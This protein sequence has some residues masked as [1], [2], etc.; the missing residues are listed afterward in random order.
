MIAYKLVHLYKDGSIGPLFI[1]R[2]QRFIIDKQYIAKCIPTKGFK[3]RPGFHCCYSMNA[4]HLSK[5][6]RVWC[7]VLIKD[8]QEHQRPLS[9]GGLW[10]TAKYMKIIKVYNANLSPVCRFQTIR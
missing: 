10:Y 3:I 4:P 2:K 9:Q 1:N 6:N 8:Y 5:K 7:K